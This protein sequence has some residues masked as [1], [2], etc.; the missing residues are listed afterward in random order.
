MGVLSKQDTLVEERLVFFVGFIIIGI[1][2]CV[3][4]VIIARRDHGAYSPRSILAS[5]LLVLAAVAV[6][7]GLLLPTGGF[8]PAKEIQTIELKSLDGNIVALDGGR[9]EYLISAVEEDDCQ[10]PRLVE[11]S[12]DAKISFWSFGLGYSKCTVVLYIPKG[13][14]AP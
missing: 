8:G 10:I 2:F 11:Y 3:I 5:I 13:S 12:Q 9:E 14:L 6:F 1:I 7:L 4:A